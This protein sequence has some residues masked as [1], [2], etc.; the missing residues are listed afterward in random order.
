M[1]DLSFWDGTST[2]FLEC[3]F[4]DVLVLDFLAFLISAAVAV[5]TSMVVLEISISSRGALGYFV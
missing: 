2:K 3:A 1:T 4:G 5:T